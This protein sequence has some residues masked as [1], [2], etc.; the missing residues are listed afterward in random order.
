MSVQS[1]LYAMIQTALTS[2]VTLKNVAVRAK[3]A[4]IHYSCY[5]VFFFIIS[6]IFI[7]VVRCLRITDV[8]N[9]Q[10]LGTCTVDDQEYRIGQRF[11]PK[12]TMYTCLCTSD[13]NSELP[14]ASNP[15]CIRINCGMEL[16][17]EDL[18]NGCVPIY[19]ETPSDC[20][21]GWKCRKLSIVW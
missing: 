16:R 15:N 4:V 14:Y 13:F 6:F 10:S 5:Y 3:Y 12:Q 8:N 1:I 21:I 17:S 19:N 11:Y 7:A 2:T 9:I 20:A 18:R